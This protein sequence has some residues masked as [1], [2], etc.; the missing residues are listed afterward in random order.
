MYL[1]HTTACRFSLLSTTFIYRMVNVLALHYQLRFFIIKHEIC[2]QNCEC[3]WV[4]LPSAVFHYWAQHLLTEWW[5]RLRHTTTCS[6]SLLSTTFKWWM[7]LH[8]TTTCSFSLLNTAFIYRMINVL[9]SHYR[10]QFFAIE[11][12][13]YLQNDE[14]ACVTL[15]LAVFYYWARHLNDE[16]AC[17]TLPPAV[18]HDWGR[19]LFKK[20][21]MCL[22]HTTAYGFSLLS[23]TFI[24]RMVSVLSSHYCL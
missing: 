3:A 11:H 10:L 18:F 20:W 22:R 23:T 24:Y 1:R 13:I 12:E 4:T 15:P 16:C 8:H 6:F 14:C 2:L 17:V 7:R 9:A 21:R 19:H 5:M